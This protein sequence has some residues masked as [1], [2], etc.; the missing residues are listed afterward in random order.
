MN[1]IEDED[2]TNLHDQVNNVDES[3]DYE[4]TEITVTYFASMLVQVIVMQTF[5][6]FL[7]FFMI[8]LPEIN[9]TDSN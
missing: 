9:T 8:L 2:F 7:S 4:S 1:A 5:G 3:T 6:A